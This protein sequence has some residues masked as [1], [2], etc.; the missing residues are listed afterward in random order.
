M[1]PPI[2]LGVWCM[3]LMISLPLKYYTDTSL[4]ACSVASNILGVSHSKVHNV[5]L[6]NSKSP[7]NVC[8]Y[9]LDFNISHKSRETIECSYVSSP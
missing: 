3:A 1:A 4:C 5:W 8:I 9:T 2:N 6:N 7:E